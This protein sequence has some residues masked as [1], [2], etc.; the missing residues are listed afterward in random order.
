MALSSPYESEPV[1]MESKHWFINAVGSLEC[2][3]AARELLDILLRVEKEFGRVRQVDDQG[4][5]DRTIDMDLLFYDEMILNSPSLQ[6]PHPELHKRL[7]VLMPLNELAPKLVHPK[8]KLSIAM[9]NKRLLLQKQLP[10]CRLQ[11]TGD[12]G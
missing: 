9:L 1:D 3:C 6:L 11:G 7:F 4:H 8:Q 5:Q 2:S 10:V 12:W